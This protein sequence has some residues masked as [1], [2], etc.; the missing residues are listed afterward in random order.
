MG[1]GIL[2][3]LMHARPSMAP[4]GCFLRGI[5]PRASFGNWR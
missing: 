4:A 2:P 5:L 1:R 3:L